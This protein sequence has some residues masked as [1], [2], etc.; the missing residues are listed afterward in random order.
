[1]QK[2]YKVVY[3]DEDSAGDYLNISNKGVVK[4]N[5][6]KSISK[7]KVKS[8][9][10]TPKISIVAP[11]SI[12]AFFASLLWNNEIV[13]F[14]SGIV[15]FLLAAGTIVLEISYKLNEENKELVGTQVTST[16]LSQFL[17]KQGNDRQILCI[18]PAG[19]HIEE[20]SF[21]SIKFYE[22]ILKMINI[23]SEGIDISKFGD[24]MKETKGYY[25]L[26]ANMREDQS[27]EE[28]Y[29]ILRLNAESF[30]NN[31]KL[32][33]LLHMKLTYYGIK[34]GKMSLDKMGF[35]QMFDNKEESN[36]TPKQAFYHIN[37]GK[38]ISEVESISREYDVIDVI[39]AGVGEYEEN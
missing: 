15:A 34:V 1:M 17:E 13:H 31:H 38:N 16:I 22:P 11:A 26:R 18:S 29:Y 39:L 2:M 36:M 4:E 7:Q 33:V 32:T 14:I 5:T 35:Q 20:N 30:R 25:E 21:S 9:A 24:V 10:I 3:F 12:I 19:V 28:N 27:E 8:L 37:Q 6:E 23:A